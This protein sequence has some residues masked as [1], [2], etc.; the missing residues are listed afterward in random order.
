M[1]ITQYIYLDPLIDTEADVLAMRKK[2]TLLMQE[3]KTTMEWT[4]EGTSAKKAF[5]CPVL[6][7]LAETRYFLK[8]KNPQKY[9]Y[10]TTRNKQIRY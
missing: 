9:G 4:G 7:I 2:A 8:S 10:I 6:D 3:G 1:A 5:V